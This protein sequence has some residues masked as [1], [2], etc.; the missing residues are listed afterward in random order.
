MNDEVLIEIMRNKPHK[1]RKE[2]IKDRAK[3]LKGQNVHDKNLKVSKMIDR[4]NDRL[5]A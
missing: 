4:L 2:W 3:K 5:N 1:I